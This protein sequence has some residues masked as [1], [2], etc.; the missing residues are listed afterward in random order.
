A[1]ASLPAAA[2][3]SALDGRS[4]VAARGGRWRPAEGGGGRA[5]IAELVIPERAI[6][7]A[8]IEDGVKYVAS[9]KTHPPPERAAVAAAYFDIVAAVAKGESEPQPLWAAPQA[10]ELYDLA[11]DPG[12]THDL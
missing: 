3:E 9:V 8:V 10:E 6:V 12:E 11:A 2:Q 1:L 5:V 4:L 7:R